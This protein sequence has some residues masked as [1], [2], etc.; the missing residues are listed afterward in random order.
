[1]FSR[2]LSRHLNNANGAVKTED[3]ALLERSSH[4]LKGLSGTFGAK[5]LFELA[6]ATNEQCI[7][8]QVNLTQAYKMIEECEQILAWVRSTHVKQTVEFRDES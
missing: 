3:L 6:S 1:M 4:G 7:N 2:D 8:G 5:K